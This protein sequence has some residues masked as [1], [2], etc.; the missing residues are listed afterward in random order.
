MKLNSVE[1]CAGAGGQALGLEAAG[2][3]H[4][5]LVEYDAY[6]CQTL[7]LN[8]PKWTVIEKDLRAVEANELE[9]GQQPLHLL[10]GGIPCPPFSVA[11]KQLGKNDERDLFPEVLRLVEQLRP[12]ALLIENVK[13]LMS[14]RFDAYRAE[15]SASL[16]GFG[17]QVVAWEVLEASKYGVPQ[18]R[19][20]SVL[21]ALD[22]DAVRHFEMPQGQG[23]AP[24]VGQALAPHLT[25]WRGVQAWASNANEIA[26]TLVGGSRK[27]GGA[28]LGPTGAK[29]AWLRLGVNG[30][31]LADAPPTAD[32]QGPLTLTVE[33]AAALQGFPI[34]WEFQGGKTARY[35]QVGN[36]FPPPVAKAVGKAIAKALRQSSS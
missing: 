27:H 22:A 16:T 19:P 33:H 34:D 31:L 3:R 24:T 6:A 1:I 14:R 15:I 7:R 8:R 36:A 26:P 25:H 12:R 2:F 30:K 32:F 21:V 9:V 18:R 28:D 20:R 13:G 11:G 17:L 10:A 4:L 35:R 23:S 5:A 29:A